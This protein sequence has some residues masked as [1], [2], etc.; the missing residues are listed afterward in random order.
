MERLTDIA[1]EFEN[2]LADKLPDATRDEIKELS[3]YITSEIYEKVEKV[4]RE[5]TVQL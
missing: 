3:L 4:S 1:L 5:Y 2:T